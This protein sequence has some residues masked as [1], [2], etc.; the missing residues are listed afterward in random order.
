M[1][2]G[3]QRQIL[4]EAET[5]RPNYLL[6]GTRMRELRLLDLSLLAYCLKV[7]IGRED[8][9]KKNCYPHIQNMTRCNEL[10]FSLHPKTEE[11]HEVWEGKFH[12][13]RCG[14]GIG[15]DGQGQ[16]DDG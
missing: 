14:G 15:V 3:K 12:G 11:Y 8:G 13:S 1:L 6:R 2:E 16:V 9:G 5:D 7:N 10:H 4:I